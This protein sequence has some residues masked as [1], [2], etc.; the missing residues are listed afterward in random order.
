MLY[1]NLL[2]KQQKKSGRSWSGSQQPQSPRIQKNPQNQFLSIYIVPFLIFLIVDFK[3]NTEPAEKFKL[4][5]LF[6]SHIRSCLRA[7]VQ[8]ISACCRS[9]IWIQIYDYVT[10]ISAIPSP[11]DKHSHYSRQLL[12]SIFKKSYCRSKRIF[13]NSGSF[14]KGQKRALLLSFYW[15]KFSGIKCTQP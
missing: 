15:K 5:S 11:L 12:I 2:W 10:H 13:Q 3:G 4:F 14:A 8:Q 1:V 6:R 9:H 7:Q